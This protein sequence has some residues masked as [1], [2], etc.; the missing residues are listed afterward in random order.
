M[1]NVTSKKGTPGSWI[2]P[3]DNKTSSSTS[4]SNTING[5]KVVGEVKVVNANVLNIRSKPST[6]SS[7]LGTVRRNQTLPIAG[8][9]VGWWEVIYNGKRAYVSDKYAKRVK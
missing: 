7:V 4:S 2:N 1:I 3:A 9:V 5:I 8:S 6:S